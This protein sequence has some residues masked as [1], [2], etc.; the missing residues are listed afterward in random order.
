M[1]HR[2]V[3][4]L[5]KRTIVAVIS[6]ILSYSE[7][8]H[9]RLRVRVRCVVHHYGVF[10]PWRYL[11]SSSVDDCIYTPLSS[12]SIGLFS[13][14]RQTLCYWRD[15]S[16]FHDVKEREPQ[17]FYYLISR[18]CCGLP[19]FCPRWCNLVRKHLYTIQTMKMT[20][21]S[22]CFVSF[23]FVSVVYMS[24]LWRNPPLFLT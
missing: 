11:S 15:K 24:I 23:F 5:P 19:V 21:K 4:L 10:W 9:R 3:A 6:S 14:A 17:H 12:R 16:V 7:V 8:L 22:V 18:W 20:Q 2:F 13:Q 1:T